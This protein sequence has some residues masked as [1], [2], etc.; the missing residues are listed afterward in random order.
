M[1]LNNTAQA[2]DDGMSSL[3]ACASVCILPM[4]AYELGR[5]F[6]LALPTRI[7]RSIIFFLALL[8]KPIVFSLLL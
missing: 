8:T 2:Q 1:M 4:T 3:A 7:K 5:L 6:S